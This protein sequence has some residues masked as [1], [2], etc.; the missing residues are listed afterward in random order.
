MAEIFYNILFCIK[1]IM[2]NYTIMGIPSYFSYIV[3]NHPR[4]IRKLCDIKLQINN[5]YLDCNSI[6]YDSISKIDFKTLEPEKQTDAIISMVCNKIEEYIMQLKPNK[7]VYI[8]FDGVAPVAKLDQQRDRRFKSIYQSNITR[9]ILKTT[10]SDPW[11]TAAI[12][13]GT[14]FMKKLNDECRRYFSKPSKYSLDNIILSGS[15]CYGEGEHK[16]FEHIR[17][18]PEKHREEVTIIYGL[19]ADLIML[20]I[21]HL[22]I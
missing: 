11:N 4:I 22:P 10:G 8:A 12:T 5:V 7:C 21:N 9:S 3:R 18:N 19:D 15:D 13:P 20:S 2:I 14:I 16:L 6:I 1:H 17:N